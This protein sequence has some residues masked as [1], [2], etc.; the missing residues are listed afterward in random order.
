MGWFWL[1]LLA[2]VFLGLYEIAKKKAVHENAVPPVL[3]L[4]T[5]TS[6]LVWIAMIVIALFSSD[7]LKHRSILELSAS[8][9]LLLILKS[10]IVGASWTFAFAALKHLPISIASPIRATS[11]FWT[12]AMAVLFLAE[13]PSALQWIGVVLILIAFLIFSWA[14]QK[15]GIV[16]HSNRW[17]TFMVIAT[18]IGAASGIYDKYLLQTVQLSPS[19]VQAWFSIYL[20][21]IMLPLAFHW[22][23]F[24]RRKT[25]FHWRWSIPL[26]ALFLL[27]SDF[28]Y[29]TALADSEALISIVSPLRRSSILIAFVFGVFWLRE[30]NWK[31]KLTA[32]LILLSGIFAIGL[33]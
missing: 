12:I 25:P 27:C 6:A 9:H 21:P 1:T 3:L 26:I 10:F 4:Y 30:G 31:Y 18:V 11:P 15:E 19:T 8:Q 32:I 14:G 29:F 23:R 2:A 20:V 33:G 24:E 16:F 22:W 17:I 5:A 13:R 7:P 28:L